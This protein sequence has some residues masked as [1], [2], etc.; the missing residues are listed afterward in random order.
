M[1][2]NFKPE[3]IFYKSISNKLIFL[4]N[5][6]LKSEYIKFYIDKAT[7]QQTDIGKFT[8]FKVEQYVQ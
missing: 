1:S 2:L 4:Q 5:I 7:L 6:N 3:F 8:P